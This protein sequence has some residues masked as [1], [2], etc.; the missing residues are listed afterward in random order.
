VSLSRG[1]NGNGFN[2]A[3][4]A[5]SLFCEG[6]VTEASERV[7]PRFIDSHPS[8]HVLLGTLFEVKASFFV[9]RLLKAGADDRVAKPSQPRHVHPQCELCEPQ[10]FAHSG[11]QLA[12]LGFLFPQVSL[13]RS[14]QSIQ[15]SAPVVRCD[16][17]FGGDPSR[18]LHAVQGGIERPFLD[19]E[20]IVGH[21]PDVGRDPVPVLGA[22]P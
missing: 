19:T 18:L 16:L 3:P 1:T 20:D 5:G 9:E 11:R 12:P 2:K 17:P 6:D 4:L 22:A 15:P 7:V 14:R 8:V 13:T 10:H 21:G